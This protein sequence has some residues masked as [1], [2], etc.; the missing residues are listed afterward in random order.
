MNKYIKFLEKIFN[1]SFCD[2]FE[3]IKIN[4]KTLKIITPFK[5]SSNDLIQ[6]FIQFDNEKIKITDDG[7]ITHYFDVKNLDISIIERIT[8]NYNLKFNS[9]EIYALIDLSKNDLISEKISNLIQIM[10]LLS[11]I[12]IY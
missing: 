8:K 7:Y 10:I 12:D 3:L 9:N 6:F 5:D 4:Y 11:N 2:N 1:D